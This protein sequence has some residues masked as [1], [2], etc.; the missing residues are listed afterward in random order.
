MTPM[1]LP[2]TLMAILSAMLTITAAPVAS[3][4]SLPEDLID[5]IQE[6]DDTDECPA[7][8][9][10]Q[11]VLCIV[12]ETVHNN[13][14]VKRVVEHVGYHYQNVSN[15]RNYTVLQALNITWETLDYEWDVERAT[16]TYTGA[17]T[18][19]ALILVDDAGAIGEDLERYADETVEGE[20]VFLIGTGCFSGYVDA[21]RIGSSLQED[22]DY[23]PNCAGLV[24]IIRCHYVSVANAALNQTD[25]T[26]DA[27]LAATYAFRD[28]Q[29]YATATYVAA[30]NHETRE[31]G[32]F[33]LG[34]T[35]DTLVYMQ[36]FVN[37]ECRLVY[38]GCPATGVGLDEIANPLLLA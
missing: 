15:A 9:L 26:T 32:R 37:R 16:Y 25:E 33:V 27:T 38:S 17:T 35:S 3:A 7:Q 2:A 21:S 11:L 19:N 10:D 29:D 31:Y 1:K 12:N 24:G 14:I 22:G 18:Y 4:D 20:C 5:S 8:H 6:D 13:P 30:V 34:A 23:G 28:R 36:G